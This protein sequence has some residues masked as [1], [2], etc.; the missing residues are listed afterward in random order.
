ML[1]Y[2]LVQNKTYLHQITDLVF[3]KYNCFTCQELFLGWIFEVLQ[4]LNSTVFFLICCTV[5]TIPLLL[6]LLLT[7][8]SAWYLY[9]RCCRF[10][11]GGSLVQETGHWNRSRVISLFLAKLLT[12]ILPM[13]LIIIIKWTDQKLGVSKKWNPCNR[14]IGLPLQ[15]EKNQ[16]QIISKALW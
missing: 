12:L 6:Q 13:Y 8:I 16:N 11:D 2:L 1:E 3:W 14:L 10:M 9:R 15:K 7:Q 5:D 4:V